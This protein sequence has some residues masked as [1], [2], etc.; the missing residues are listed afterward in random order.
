MSIDDNE[1]LTLLRSLR[2]YAERIGNT[3]ADGASEQSQQIAPCAKEAACLQCPH[4]GVQVPLAAKGPEKAQLW[5]VMDAANGDDVSC[6]F[7][8]TGE[9]REMFE[10]MMEHVLGL[11]TSQIHVVNAVRCSAASGKKS[12]QEACSDRLL[13]EISQEKPSW[14]LAMGGAALRALTKSDA[15]I[16][17]V[18]GEWMDVSGV[19]ILATF[20]PRY[21][22]RAPGHKRLVFQ[23]LQALKARMETI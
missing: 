4:A 22:V 17:S 19:P 9:A 12:A 20:H 10:K 13:E 1:R 8:I 21:L 14:V 11:S 2:G 16:S 18:R 7:P 3:G 5:V 23:D 6:D 15:N